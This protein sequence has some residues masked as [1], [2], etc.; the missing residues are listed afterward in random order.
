MLTR[1][2]VV[3]VLG[4]VVLGVVPFTFG[5]SWQ[6]GL[7]GFLAFLL[8]IGW[9]LLWWAMGDPDRR[10][11]GVAVILGVLGGLVLGVVAV[12]LYCVPANCAA[13]FDALVLVPAGALVGAVLGGG[14]GTALRGPHRQAR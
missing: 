4:L 3:L 8:A 9:V 12:G 10:L 7:T 6:R 11:A 14:I 13:G 2:N 1:R 5:A